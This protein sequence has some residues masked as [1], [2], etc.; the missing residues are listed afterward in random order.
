MNENDEGGKNM[1]EAE[2]LEGNLKRNNKQVKMSYHKVIKLDF[3][4]TG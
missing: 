1:H 4:K 2:F 3:A